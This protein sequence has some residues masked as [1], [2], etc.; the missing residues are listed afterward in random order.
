[1]L[2]CVCPQKVQEIPP[3]LQGP[4]LI[5][6]LPFS[7]PLPLPQPRAQLSTQAQGPGSS[8]LEPRSNHPGPTPVLPLCP[9]TSHHLR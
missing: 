1:M 5:P 3:G 7:L 9:I 2:L 8:P 4:P 6:S